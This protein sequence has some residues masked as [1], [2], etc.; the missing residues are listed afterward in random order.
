MNWKDLKI[1][2]KLLISSSISLVFSVLIGIVGI[3]NLNTINDNTNMMAKYYLQVVNNSYKLD[4]QWH[5]VV[6]YLDNF[7]YSSRE[8]FSNKVM[9]QTAKTLSAIELINK[10]AELAELSEDNKAKL[11]NVKNQIDQFV[12][13]FESYKTEVERTNVIIGNLDN[14]KESLISGSNN[15]MQKDVFETLHFINEIRINQ[16]PTKML[17]LTRLIGKLNANN[18]VLIRDLAK[19]ADGFKNAYISSR[20]LELKTTEISL[21]ILADIKGITEVVL[22]S[23]TENSETTNRITEKSTIY[24]IISMLVALILGILFSTLI[25][26]SITLPITESVEIAKELAA[27]NLTRKI[28]TNR[29]DEIGLLL[30]SL[31]LITGSISSVVKD[32]NES[33][34]QIASA[35]MELNS[36]SQQLAQGANEQAAASEEIASSME[37]MA[38]NVRQSSENAQITGDIAKTSSIGIVEGTNSAKEA[39]LSMKEIANKVT[40]IS[41]IAFQTNLLAL[42]AAVEAA[43]AGNAGK[44]FSVVAAE[45]RKLAE[46]SKLAAIDIEKLAKKTMAIS[47]IAGDKLEKVTPEIQKTA[48]LVDVI[49]ESSIDQIRGIDQMN[50]AMGQLNSGTQGAVSNS[51]KVS[52]SAEE[53]MAQAESLLKI[54][55]FFKISENEWDEN[56]AYKIQSEIPFEDNVRD[57]ENVKHVK[58]EDKN[59]NKHSNKLNVTTKGFNL[60]LSDSERMDEGFEKY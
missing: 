2:K 21:N 51:E 46:R 40:V 35:G 25:S 34:K 56:E 53:L 48:G 58:L 43:R 9:V 13:V 28:D 16:K 45:V 4:K 5:E 50:A 22:D 17:E 47:T 30:N 7:N 19:N 49:A 37:E 39:I 23:F 32:I 18:D 20:E 11:L 26:R 55:G 44:G 27:G 12:L 59:E 31:N 14:L 54:I 29:K 42:N 36:S 15:N 60:N 3:I 52:A 33:A 1:F 6:N 41:D 8:Y 38:A 57:F 10:N 24:L